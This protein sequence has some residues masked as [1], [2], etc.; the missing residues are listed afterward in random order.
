MGI[1]DVLTG[2]RKP[3]KLPGVVALTR[4]DH[5]KC[6]VRVVEHREHPQLP[7]RYF[8]TLEGY[9]GAGWIEAPSAIAATNAKR[10]LID[11]LV[12]DR[13]GARADDV[14]AGLEALGFRRGKIAGRPIILEHAKTGAALT[15]PHDD[16][17]IMCRAEIELIAQAAGVTVDALED[18]AG[19]TALRELEAARKTIAD[20]G[21]RRQWADLAANNKR[22]E[23]ERARKLATEARAAADRAAAELARMTGGDAA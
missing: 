10:H 3:N 4:P 19:I 20:E 13:G 14:R 8:A 12:A 9:E 21:S 15:W 23:A 11:R 5:D 7:P 17:A 22:I 16:G 2:G 6:K 18:A 1:R